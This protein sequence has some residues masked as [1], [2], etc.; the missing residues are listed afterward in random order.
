MTVYE[1]INRLN[2]I[3]DKTR[4]VIVDGDDLYN[5]TNIIEDFGDLICR[6]E[7]KAIPYED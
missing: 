5:V 6:L 7:V 4:P 1:L 3:E 2:K